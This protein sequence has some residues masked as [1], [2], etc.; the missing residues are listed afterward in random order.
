MCRTLDVF[1]SDSHGFLRHR[2]PISTSPR[3]HQVLDTSAHLCY[4]LVDVAA[5]VPAGSN[6]V[7]GGATL[8][9]P[10]P[11]TTGPTPAPIPGHNDT[12]AKVVPNTDAVG[13]QR[14]PA[15]PNGVSGST[16]QSCC[17]LC[18]ADA[19]CSF[20]VRALIRGMRRGS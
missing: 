3:R 15:H 5:R 17:G 14:T 8:P 20:W 10:A 19:D 11:P 7:T 18:N 12:C 6:R 9:T 1:V 4:L 16:Q 2:G 13:G